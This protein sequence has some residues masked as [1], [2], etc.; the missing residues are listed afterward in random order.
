MPKDV[1]QSSDSSGAYEGVEE[2][3]RP[4]NR[5]TVFVRYTYEDDDTG[6]TW[7]SI[8]EIDVNALDSLDA[9]NVAQAALT[10]DYED[11]GRVVEVQER[12]KGWMYL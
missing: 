7:S 2:P 4:L 12:P 11:G 9:E 10:R 5:Y 6:E 8:E 1:R 3:R